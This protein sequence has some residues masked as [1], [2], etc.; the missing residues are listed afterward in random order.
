MTS[1]AGA[2]RIIEPK[3]LGFGAASTP[4]ADYQYMKDGVMEEVRRIFKP[5]FL[6][7]IDE[8]IVFHALTKENM[9]RIVDIMMRELGKTDKGPD[10]NRAGALRGGQGPDHRE[11]PTTRSTA[12]GPFGAPSRARSRISW[13][14]RSWRAP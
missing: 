6:N 3:K 12:Q 10:G 13:R 1:N 2:S 7:R 8:T 9:A 14:S 5:E 11:G 4:E